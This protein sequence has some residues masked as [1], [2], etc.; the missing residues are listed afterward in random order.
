[1]AR[2]KG[3]KFAL[4]ERPRGGKGLFVLAGGKRRPTTRLLYDVSKSAVRV[5]PTPTLARTLRRVNARTAAILHRAVLDEL[6][7]AKVFGY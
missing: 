1:M 3:I 6:R 2:R 4:L 5:P 7:R